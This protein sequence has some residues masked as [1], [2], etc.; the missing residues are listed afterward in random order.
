MPD[1]DQALAILGL[2]SL[3]H[4]EPG[5]EDVRA[6]LDTLAGNLCRRYEEHAHEGWR[7]FE[8]K[9]TYDNAMVP[10]GLFMAYRVTGD[11]NVHGPLSI[12]LPGTVAGLAL[13]HERFGRLPWHALL[14]PAIEL[15]QPMRDWR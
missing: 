8:P 6:T 14:Q 12:G 7:W 2:E 10:L 1:P 13:A 11:R 4:A 9:L 5:A 15:A 3:L